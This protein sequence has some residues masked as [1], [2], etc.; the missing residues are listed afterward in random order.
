MPLVV[1]FSRKNLHLLNDQIDKM[2]D[3]VQGILASSEQDFLIAYKGQMSTIHKQLAAFKKKIN[4]QKFE[5]KKDSKLR[6]L[7]AEVDYFQKEALHYRE[8][9]KQATQHIKDV[10]V[11]NLNLQDD[12][13][14]LRRALL[15]TKVKQKALERQL[16]ESKA[17]NLE[18]VKNI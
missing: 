9:D 8:L 14:I 5:M 4:T 17:E 11:E 6:S 2:D 13:Y 12:T 10:H 16:E 3:M 7:C 1:C 18:L 15:N